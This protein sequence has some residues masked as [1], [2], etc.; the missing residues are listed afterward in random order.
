MPNITGVRKSCWDW[1]ESRGTYVYEGAIY[2]I[3]S[4]KATGTGHPEE[5]VPGSFGFDASLSN[6]IYKSTNV[7]Q[8]VS[9]MVSSIV[10]F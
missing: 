2:S 9:L 6:S 7:V 3:N 4:L 5:Q 1:N 10:R 8:P